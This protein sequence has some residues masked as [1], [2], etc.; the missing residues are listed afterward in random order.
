MDHHCHWLG[1]CIGKNNRK[2]FLLLLGYSTTLI[3]VLCSLGLVEFFRQFATIPQ[4]WAGKEHLRSAAGEEGRGEIAIYIPSYLILTAMGC[5]TGALL[6]FQFQMVLRDETTLEVLRREV[7]CGVQI[8]GNNPS[9]ENFKK[10]FGQDMFLWALP[11]SEDT[12]EEAPERFKNGIFGLTPYQSSPIGI[13]EEIE[14]TDMTP[15]CNESSTLITKN[16]VFS[17][18]TPIVN[19]TPL[20]HMNPTARSAMSPQEDLVQVSI[21]A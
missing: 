21:V 6:S 13:P 4:I 19:H 14:L 20:L 12:L 15:I 5:I 8:T 7:D 9:M 16:E 11:W 2:A 3:F 17:P 18:A 1:T 10:V